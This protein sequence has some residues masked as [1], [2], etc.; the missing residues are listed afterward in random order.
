M[1]YR[2]HLLLYQALLVY[3]LSA[4]TY[5]FSNHVQLQTSELHL[6]TS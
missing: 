3:A 2:A 6:V 1:L 4:L 5:K